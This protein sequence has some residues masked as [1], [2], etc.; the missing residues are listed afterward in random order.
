MTFKT[1]WEKT[2]QHFQVSA[3]TI[4]DMVELAL[5]GKKLASHEII[6]G[7]CANLNIKLN[8][9]DENQP[10]IL[11]LYV[12]DKAAA[13]REQKLAALIKSSVPLPEVYFVGD[14]EGHR[15]AITEYMPGLNL[16]DLLLNHPNGNIESIMLQVGQILASIQKYQFPISGFF[17]DDLKV[18]DPLSR[19]SYTHSN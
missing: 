1:L 9:T 17:D 12:R 19:Q 8:L 15:F 3:Q 4:Q 18:S 11:R 13:Y 7:G 10:L 5:P 6:S 14:F 16:R 2:D